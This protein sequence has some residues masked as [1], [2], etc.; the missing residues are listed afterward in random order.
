MAHDTLAPASR[1]VVTREDDVAVRFDVSGVVQGVGFRPFVYR[2]ATEARLDGVV[3]NDSTRVFIEVTGLNARIEEFAQ[4][5][6]DEAPPL[7]HIE[8]VT[9]TAIPVRSGAGFRIADSTAVDGERTL[10]PPDT[11]VCHDCLREL[12]DPADRRH[13]HPFITCTNC[14]PR[15]TIIRDLPYDRPATTM[16]GFEMC[17]ACAHEY[18]DPSDRRYHAQPIACPN[19]GPVLEFRDDRIDATERVV[20]PI[21]AAAAA[22]RSGDIVAIKGLGG[23][24]L[25]CDAADDE[26]VR[27]LRERKHRPDKPFALMVADLTAAAGLA[28]IGPVEADQLVSPG[29]PIVLLRSREGASTAISDAIAPGSPL[30]GLMLP[31]TPVHHLLFASG[32]PALVMTSGNLSGEPLAYRDADASARLGDIC[33]AWLTHDRPI[34]VPC[35]DSVVRIVGDELLPIRRARGFAPLPVPVA[36]IDRS[37]LA[38]GGELKN[39]FCLASPRHAWMSQHLGDMENLATL[40]SFERGVEQF[41]HIYDIAPEVVA[42]DLHPGYRTSRWAKTNHAGR[43]VEVQHH[44]A[45]IASVMAEHGCDP[46]EPVIGFAFDGTGYGDDGAIWGGEVLL[47]D[48]HGYERIAH[49]APIDLPGGDAAIGNPCRVALAHLAAAGV[50]WSDDL[51]PVRALTPS[52]LVVL[53]RQLDQKIVCVPTTSMGR[54]FDAVASLLGLRHRISYEAQAAIELEVAADVAIHLTG[55]YRFGVDGPLMTPG[56]VLRAI[57]ADLRA[58]VPIGEIA[59]AFHEAVAEVVVS[60]AER[61][62]DERGDHAVALSGGVFQNALLTV[63]CTSRL[64]DAGFVVLTHHLVPPNDGGL[65]LGQA[66]VAGHR[67]PARPTTRADF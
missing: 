60:T 3:G 30:L 54:L 35:D 59:R 16:A 55:R 20:D 36:A 15:F 38:V 18:A 49:L 4:R 43:V 22:L 45:H 25:A 40:D 13:R 7:A 61:L 39:A 44:H 12:A 64:S 11:G 42:V 37:V 66:F 52:E 23:F 1:V 24:H 51:A 33:D 19:C 29:R 2:L 63:M 56:P 6:V 32:A 31:S 9:R 62:R 14:G 47:A 67:R 17:D 34:H 48:A 27:R 28:E 21:E 58:N 65:A 10:I 5:L 53:R 46:D 26:V 50:E 41:G 8:T 57:V